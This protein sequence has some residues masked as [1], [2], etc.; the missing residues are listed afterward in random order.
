MPTSLINIAASGEQQA[1]SS[2][3]SSHPFLI[4]GR[5][6][7]PH[8]RVVR[9]DD[10]QRKLAVQVAAEGQI[11]CTCT[12]RPDTASGYRIDDIVHHIGSW[13]ALDIHSLF[14][15]LLT[16]AR[17]VDLIGVTNLPVLVD[18][19][20]CGVAVGCCSFSILEYEGNEFVAVFC[21]DARTFKFAATAS[22]WNALARAWDAEAA[23]YGDARRVRI[24]ECFFRQRGWMP[25]GVRVF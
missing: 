9:I 6:D 23:P 15:Q 21:D 16:P 10:K 1:P 8:L 24:A 7:R 3:A 13:P 25:N 18:K 5:R 11:L 12:V 17:F 4:I 19:L 2:A 20:T 22:D 14:K